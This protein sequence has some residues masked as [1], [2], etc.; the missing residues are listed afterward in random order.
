[1]WYNVE[2]SSEAIDNLKKEMQRLQDEAKRLMAVSKIF[3]EEIIWEPLGGCRT[4]SVVRSGTRKH[5]DFDKSNFDV[6]D[7]AA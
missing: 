4:L 1:M 2:Y 3:D 6:A 5:R 7:R